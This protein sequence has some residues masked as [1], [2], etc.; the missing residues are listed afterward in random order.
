[1]F[2]SLFWRILSFLE[3]AK[4]FI[5]TDMYE[6]KEYSYIS[7]IFP[8]PVIEKKRIDPLHDTSL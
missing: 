5:N 2:L 3:I 7:E 4:A 6:F 8:R 1:M